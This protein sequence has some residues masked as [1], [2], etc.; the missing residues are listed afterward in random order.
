[1]AQAAFDERNLALQAFKELVYGVQE[2]L[3]QTPA[4]RAVRQGLLDT[5]IAGL[6]QI[7]ERTAGSPPDLSQAAAHEK[8][9]DMYRIIGR[10]AD[11]GEQYER[12]RELAED[13][14][15]LDPDN[16]AIGEVLY[17]TRMGLG[18]LNMATER[19][20]L[21]KTEFELAATISAVIAAADPT[22]RC[23]ARAA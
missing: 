9:G 13:L 8:L 7:S 19:F 3:G 23:G 14:L 2:K 20:A 4:T 5:A 12:S 18:L 6:E 21:A 10:Y 22:A 17:H 16:I 1:M 11:A 15:A